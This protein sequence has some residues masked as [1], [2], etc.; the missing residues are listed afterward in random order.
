MIKIRRIL[1]RALKW[2]LFILKGVRVLPAYVQYWGIFLATRRIVKSI[3]LPGMNQLSQ[4]MMDFVE[5][6]QSQ[7]KL[8]RTP[9]YVVVAPDFMSNSAGICCLYQLCSDLRKLGFETAI[10]GSQ[11]GSASF[12][13]PL[14]SKRD[15]IKAAK[16]G[17]WV[18][19]PEIVSGN[20]LKA[21][22]IVRWALNRPGLLG[23]EDVY[24]DSEHVFVY[25][26]VFAPYVKNQIRGRLYMPT[27]NRSLFY[28]PKDRN[29]T[30]SLDCYYVGKSRYKDGVV[31]PKNAL[32]ITRS[33]PPKSELGKIFRSAR[34]LY[35][36]DNST[37]LIYEALFCGCPVV[38]IPD[39]T[40]TWS[41][42]EKLELGTSGITWGAPNGSIEPFDSRK[43]N[44]KLAEWE[45]S[46]ESQLAFLVKYTQEIARSPFMD[47]KTIPEESHFP[48]VTTSKPH[49]LEINP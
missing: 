46:Y 42:Y 27:I 3:L 37:A 43:L 39:G 20:P 36:F 5:L 45:R 9:D 44:D 16:E 18:I 14:I 15:A 19:Y 21:K 10:R 32:E 29:Q 40:Q 38:I 48:R 30:R 33:T 24:P 8:K 7:V 1:T 23:G 35:S 49:I 47:Y 13:V 34:V 31:D 2:I 22:N 11:K 6:Q 17:A 41:D 4:E 26:D 12:P 25:S 28:P